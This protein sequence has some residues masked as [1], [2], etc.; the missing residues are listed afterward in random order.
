MREF[1]QE[2][3]ETVVVATAPTTSEAELI[4]ITLAVHGFE[5]AVSPGSSV[6]PSID[7]AQGVDVL[8]AAE[9][10]EGARELLRSLRSDR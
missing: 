8:V 6:Y 10:Q 7:F 4:K 3:T 9:D 1:E 5:A 2:R